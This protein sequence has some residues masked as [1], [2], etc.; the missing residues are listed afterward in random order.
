M[1]YGVRLQTEIEIKLRLPR[2]L[3]GIHR[4]LR[5]LGFR[6][7]KRRALETNI[8]YDDSE[9][10]LRR[11]RKLLRVRR[12][13]GTTVLTYKGPWRTARY[14]ERVELEI[15]L[16]KDGPI[17]VILESIGFRP[18]FRYEKFRT[19]Y[20][21]GTAG[22]KVLL[23]ETPIGNF[24]EIEGAPRAIDR[25]ARSLGFSVKDYITLSYGHLYLNWCR[26]NGVRPSHMVFGLT[27][28]G[29]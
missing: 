20:S 21:N 22:A 13:A 17:E 9:Q 15:G 5:A 1:H 26:Q 11:Q 16:P 18:F 14:K 3:A 4:S 27:S 28:A 8:L 10:T 12:I 23:D 7:V 6:A 24:I 19:E 2:G 25:A 29:K